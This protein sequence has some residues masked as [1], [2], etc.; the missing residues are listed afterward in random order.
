MQMC[1][2]VELQSCSQQLWFLVCLTFTLLSAVEYYLVAFAGAMKCRGDEAHEPLN[3]SGCRQ[4]EC[5]I[6]QHFTTTAQS[7]DDNC[8]HY[9]VSVTN[10]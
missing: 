2:L 10:H 9:G 4:K 8:T 3:V 6:H 5:H 1:G 7:A